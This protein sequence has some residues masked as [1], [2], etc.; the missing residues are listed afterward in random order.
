MKLTSIFMKIY[1]SFICLFGVS[2]LA[3][4][5]EISLDEVL[6]QVDAKDPSITAARFR[7]KASIENVGVAKSS[8]LPEVSLEAIDSTGFPG[9]SGL[10]G[11]GGL[12]GSPYRSG[13]AAGLVAKEV[14]WDFG[15]ISNRVGV[16]EEEASS[17]S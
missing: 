5:N 10:T 2:A 17:K 1:L 6:V 7:E 4:V 11:V 16:A 15:Q 14:L 13:V 8:Y 12:M 9:S 3:N